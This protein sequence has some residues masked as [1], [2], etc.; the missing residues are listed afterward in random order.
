MKYSIGDKVKILDQFSF[1]KKFKNAKITQINSNNTYVIEATT[2]DDNIIR[3]NYLDDDM[4]TDAEQIQYKLY[5]IGDIVCFKR[6]D[7]DTDFMIGI[8]T[9]VEPRE[10]QE[11]FSSYSISIQSEKPLPTVCATYA[12][13]I[14]CGIKLP[15]LKNLISFY[16]TGTG[17]KNIVYDLAW[18][19]KF[20]KDEIKEE[21]TDG[22]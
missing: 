6:E 19:S 8:V 14:I 18:W 5:N 4:I 11:A 12:K 3:L 1:G 22:E 2:E 15:N 20:Y 10:G 9:S 17:S 21:A 7:I 16:E 13:D